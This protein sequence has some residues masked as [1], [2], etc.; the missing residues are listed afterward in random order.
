MLSSQQTKPFL[1]F[2]P[3]GRQGGKEVAKMVGRMVETWSVNGNV[4][5]LTGKQF[6]AGKNYFT[7]T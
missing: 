6:T 5:I 3:T 7:S 4:G 1:K 2:H